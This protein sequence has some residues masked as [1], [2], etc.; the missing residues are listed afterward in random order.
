LGNRVSVQLHNY[1]MPQLANASRPTVKWS[2]VD[3]TG[4]SGVFDIVF[5]FRGNLTSSGDG[6]RPGL[7]TALRESLGLK[8]EGAR[9]MVGVLVIDALERPTP[10]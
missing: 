1:P 9:A 10:N 5:D 3:E 7:Y 4:L 2:V 6:N 8:L